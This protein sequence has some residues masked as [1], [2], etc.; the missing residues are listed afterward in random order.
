MRVSFYGNSENWQRMCLVN[1]ANA[2]RF[3]ADRAIREYA[4]NIWDAN[5]LPPAPK[6]EPQKPAA[7]KPVAAA[8][9]QAKKKK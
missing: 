7:V 5:P 8:E 6:A 1:V 2:G 3:A 4:G 9:P